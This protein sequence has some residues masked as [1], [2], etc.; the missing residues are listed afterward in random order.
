MKQSEFVAI[1]CNLLK[2]PEKPREQGAISL[3]LILVVE[4]LGQ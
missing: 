4:N 2:A 3:V 1:S